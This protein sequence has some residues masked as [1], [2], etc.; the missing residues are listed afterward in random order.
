MPPLVT[1][2]VDESAVE[3]FRSWIASLKPERPFVREWAL[4]DLTPHLDKLNEGRDL[5]R[6]KG[7]YRAVGCGQCHRIEEEIAGIGPNL[8]D[9]GKTRTPKELLESIVAPSAK[10]DPKYAATILVTID[11]LAVQGRIQSEDEEKVV[12][13]GVESFNEP[14][15]ILRSEIEERLLSNVSMMPAGILNT[16]Q[17]DEILDLM[18]YVLAG[19]LPGK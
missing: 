4:A 10:I 12:L 2:R 5:E 17:Q 1:S 9:I 6:G 7:L 15:V 18:A 8:T 19:R 14:R 11:G 16:L 13:R 3:L